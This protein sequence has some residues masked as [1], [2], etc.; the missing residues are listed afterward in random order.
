MQQ[1]KNLSE[2]VACDV[3]VEWNEAPARWLRHYVYAV[4]DA[5]D[6]GAEAC[7]FELGMP[8]S[9]YIAVDIRHHRYP[10]EDVALLW[11]ERTGWA[12]GIES[13]SGHDLRAL[14]YLGGDPHATPETVANFVRRWLAGCETS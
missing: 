12:V 4:A 8:P 5:L 13:R 7:C 14:T 3:D 6:V 1:P 11:D 2:E 10:N 9:A